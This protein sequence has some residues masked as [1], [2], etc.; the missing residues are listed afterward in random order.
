M[1]S[2]VFLGTDPE[3]G[4]EEP[5]LGVDVGLLT[6]SRYVVL[7][8]REAE[9]GFA[10]RLGAFFL[11]AAADEQAGAFVDE[12]LGMRCVVVDGAPTEVEF[13]VRLGDDLLRLRTTRTAAAQAAFDV[14]VLEDVDGVGDIDPRGW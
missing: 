5:V 10:R 14:V 13:E 1:R 11:A 6:V 2:S 12:V 9:A 8:Q 7:L 4:V 3:S